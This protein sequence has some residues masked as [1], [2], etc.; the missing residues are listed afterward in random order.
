VKSPSV[1]NTCSAY[2]SHK[3]GIQFDPHEEVCVWSSGCVKCE[4]LPSMWQT[5]DP[6][7]R[8]GFCMADRTF[9]WPVHYREDSF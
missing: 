2:E 6:S 9:P 8:E 3:E 1:N 4:S 5:I 7:I